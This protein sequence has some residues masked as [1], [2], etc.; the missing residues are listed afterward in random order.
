MLLKSQNKGCSS[1]QTSGE[2]PGTLGRI[3]N[4]VCG[5]TV[6]DE[7]CRSIPESLEG[8]NI[9]YAKNA[10]YESNHEETSGKKPN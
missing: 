8:N 1:A 6:L 7:N 3:K 9:F 4:N 10:S 5:G 2:F